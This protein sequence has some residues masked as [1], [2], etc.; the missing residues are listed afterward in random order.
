MNGLEID[1]TRLS[2]RVRSELG[3]GWEPHIWGKGELI[4]KKGSERVE[5]GPEGNIRGRYDMNHAN[6]VKNS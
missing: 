5:L 6:S 3:P 2:E 1:L 4:Y